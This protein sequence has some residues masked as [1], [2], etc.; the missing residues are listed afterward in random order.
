[1]RMICIW[2]DNDERPFKGIA[3]IDKD[4]SPN[5]VLQ[6]WINIQWGKDLK[7]GM[8]TEEE[9]QGMGLKY[10]FVDPVIGSFASRVEDD[11][12]NDGEGNVANNIRYQLCRMAKIPKDQIMP[13]DIF[14]TI[15]SR[16]SH[17]LTA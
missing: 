6:S 7:S 2:T 14:N 10:F 17:R 11:A 12:G 13:R 4:Q 9:I 15:M 1:M 8:M 16:F 3:I 5:D